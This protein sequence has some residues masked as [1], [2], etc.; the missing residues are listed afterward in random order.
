MQILGIVILPEGY[1]SNK[2]TKIEETSLQEVQS[3]ATCFVHITKKS[4]RDF[5]E[6]SIY[7]T[8]IQMRETKSTFTL[9]IMSNMMSA[10][11]HAK[12]SA[13]DPSIRSIDDETLM[14]MRETKSTFNGSISSI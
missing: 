6:L 4:D 12:K 3:R 2:A 10:F 14:H 7:K 9:P 11:L 13:N 1:V 8:S 5:L